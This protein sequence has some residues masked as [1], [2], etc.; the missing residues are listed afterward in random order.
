MFPKKTLEENPSLPLPATGGFWHSLACSCITTNSAC[1]HMANFLWASNL[2][3]GQQSLD[4]GP[5]QKAKAQW[6][7]TVRIY[8]SPREEF[9]GP[10][11]QSFRDLAPSI[12][13]RHV[14]LGPQTALHSASGQGKRKERCPYRRFIDASPGNGAHLFCPYST[15]Q[16]SNG[17]MY[18]CKGGWEM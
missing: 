16:N 15:G 17:H 18:N 14:P 3:Q 12:L 6:P 13:W 7:N 1:L 8:F 4:L 10:L 5:N 11:L 2:L 9:A